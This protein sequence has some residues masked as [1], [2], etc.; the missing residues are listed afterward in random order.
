LLLLL[1]DL[2]ER[3]DLVNICTKLMKAVKK[4][5]TETGISAPVSLSMGSAIL[6]DDTSDPVL[7]IQQADHALYVAKAE[8]RDRW[9]G[10]SGFPEKHDAKGQ[11]DPFRR[12][13]A[14]VAEQRIPAFSQPIV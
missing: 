8:G 6:P 9:R 14:A 5:I 1:T 7:L 3:G 13:A 2:R 12:L 10:I 4:R 11:A